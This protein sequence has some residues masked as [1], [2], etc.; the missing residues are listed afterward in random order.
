MYLTWEVF[1]NCQ[2]GK[3]TLGCKDKTLIRNIKFKVRISPQK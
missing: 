1:N 3:N 2:F